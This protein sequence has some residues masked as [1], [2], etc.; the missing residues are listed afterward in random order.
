MQTDNGHR[1]THL[2][3]PC[4]PDH[5]ISAVTRFCFDL[6][7]TV[8]DE[9]SDDQDGTERLQGIA[10]KWSRRGWPINVLHHAVSA[11]FTLGLDRIAARAPTDGIESASATARLF[12]LLRTTTTTVARAYLQAHVGRTGQSAAKRELALALLQGEHTSTLTRDYG[13]PVA[14]AY[15]IVPLTF[16]T[17]PLGDDLAETEI[18]CQLLRFTHTLETC[19]GDTVLALVGL[20]GGTLLITDA[21]ATGDDL[22]EFIGHL[23]KAT[24]L[25]ITATAST[26]SI[27]ISEIPST[28]HHLEEL[29]DTVHRMGRAPGIYRLKDIALEHQLIRPGPARELLR[30]R[31]KPLDEHPI[32]SATLDVYIR[33]NFNKQ[34]TARTLA[35]HVNTIA[36]RLHRISEITGRDPAQPDGIWHL[37]S[38]L[39]ARR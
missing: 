19:Y 14:D 25:P 4:V 35:V 36:Y 10:I 31:L 34:H 39:V 17:R 30:A 37:M 23:S 21:S 12:E 11:G 24:L 16:P 27:P 29:L 2:A 3:R 7:S 33:N 18:E 26:A 20:G 9:D 28:A 6:A 1:P 8:L 38:A 13:I 32:L 22:D 5:D 15:F